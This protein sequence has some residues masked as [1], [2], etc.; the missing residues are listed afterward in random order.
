MKNGFQ[1]RHIMCTSLLS[2]SPGMEINKA[3]HLLL[4][5]KISGAP[6][7]DNS[8][9]LVGVLS[10]KDCLKAVLNTHY[11]HVWGGLV[12]DYMAP[13]VFT[14]DADMDLLTV[15]H[16]FINSSY[17]RFPVMEQGKLVGQVSRSDLLLALSEHWD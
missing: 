4:N 3:M 12:Q 7:L 11:H 8:G 6:V 14:L 16:H 2:L 13:D 9:D 15:A 1:L 17:R 10:Q 5:R